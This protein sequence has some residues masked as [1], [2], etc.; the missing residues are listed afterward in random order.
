MGAR[1]SQPGQARSRP[2]AQLSAIDPALAELPLLTAD[3]GDPASL[4]AVAAS[5]RVVI[6]TVGPYLRHGEPLVAAC[7]EAGTDYLDLTGEPEFVDLM[8]ARHHSRRVRVRRPA[9]PLLRLRLD[10]ARPGRLLHGR[11]AARRRRDHRR[12]RGPGRRPAVGR[13]R[14]LGDHRLLAGA[15][16][17][18]GG[19]GPPGARAAAG[20]PARAGGPHRARAGRTG[21]G[22]CRCRRSTRRWWPARPGRCRATARTSPTHHYAG[23]RKLPVAV[24]RRARHGG[25]GRA[26]PAAA[27]PPVAAEPVRSPAPGP[28][29]EQRATGWFRVRFTA[30]GGGRRVVT[31]VAGGDPG[32]DETA[33]ML[34]ESALCVAFDDLPAAA[35][36]A[37]HRGGD[38]PAADRPADQ[39]RPAVPGAGAV[40]LR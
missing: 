22:C 30:T 4:A 14:P 6:S 23:V 18:R 5:T 39:G 16:V 37:H 32:Y 7:A 17:G 19:Q 31:E 20:R 12:R 27:D 2:R 35:G 3:A 33:K 15:G 29:A 25:A 8:Y 28:S 13:D 1:R 9:D 38:G 21:C 24:G 11:P 36:P 40:R 10:P 26:G 34:A